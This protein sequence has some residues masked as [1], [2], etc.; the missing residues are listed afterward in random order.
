MDSA[1]QFVLGACVGAAALGPRIGPRKA[2]LI[3]G[4]L[5]TVPDL[6]VFFPYDGP[7]D[8]F[9]LHRGVTHSLLV[10]ALATPLFGEAILRVFR[11]FE[12]FETPLSRM[13]VY[14]AVY[15]CFATHA[16]LDGMTVYG[17]QLLWPVSSE[18]FG[19]GS[20][21]II[22]P[23]YT[24]PLLVL[25][26]W[27]LCLGRWRERFRKGLIAAFALSTGYLAWS[28]GAQQVAIARASD[29]IGTRLPSDRFLATPVPFN[30]LFWKVVLLRDDDYVNL[31]VPLLGG[32]DDILAYAHRRNVGVLSCAEEIPDTQ[33]IA[34]FSQGFVRLEREGDSVRIADLRMGLTP[35]YVF[36]FEVGRIT[37]NGILPTVA[38][39]MAPARELS[40]DLDW[41]LNGIQ[42]KGTMRLAEQGDRVDLPLEP[43]VLPPV[44]AIC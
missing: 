37:P 32:S 33:R 34:D 28:A 9:V 16:L 25:T 27:A 8:S 7:V 11:A 29:A 3:G 6:D 43:D 22:D 36:R 13:R 17:T 38:K 10:Q 40:R 41:L 23:L 5:G 1:T 14:A 4:F 21:F 35:D 26:V 12:K 20:I 31:Y 19:Q 39:R 2:V 24:L 15:L 18:P 42:G 30:T 44:D